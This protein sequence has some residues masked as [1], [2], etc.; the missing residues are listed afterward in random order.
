MSIL[1]L[2]SSEATCISNRTIATV[3]VSIHLTVLSERLEWHQSRPVLVFNRTLVLSTSTLVVVRHGSVKVGRVRPNNEELTTELGTL[4]LRKTRLEK[5]PLLDETSMSRLA[6]NL[7]AVDIPSNLLTLIAVA[8]AEINPLAKRIA[9]KAAEHWHSREMLK[10]TTIVLV[11]VVA[12]NTLV[13]S[14][15]H[16]NTKLS[17]VVT[18]ALGL[19]GQPLNVL[20]VHLEVITV[21]VGL[22]VLMLLDR[23]HRH[24]T[25]L[26]PGVVSD[27]VVI[28][29]ILTTALITPV[30]PLHMLAVNIVRATVLPLL[31]MHVARVLRVDAAILTILAAL[32]GKRR[33]IRAIAIRG[34]A[35]ARAT[36]A[37]RAGRAA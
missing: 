29:T 27:K 9:F 16:R 37:R 30:A 18:F 20:L 1:R 7:A 24:G 4:L 22:P 36:T 26:L 5:A 2:K 35:R 15:N 14:S 32:P 13:K 12:S 28:S 33:L 3:L 34:A 11:L 31:I 17:R 23:D 19:V 10:T 8:N 6:M 21:D 25:L